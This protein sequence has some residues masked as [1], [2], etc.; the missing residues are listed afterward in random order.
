MTGA[1]LGACFSGGVDV[2]TGFNGVGLARTTGEVLGFATGTE[3]RTG[4]TTGPGWR[5]A[6]GLAVGTRV[7]YLVFG[8]DLHAGIAT[9]TLANNTILGIRYPIP[10]TSVNGFTRIDYSTISTLLFLGTINE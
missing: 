7:L 8:C 1:V 2:L 6:N 10:V 3:V 5:C 9:K 4:S